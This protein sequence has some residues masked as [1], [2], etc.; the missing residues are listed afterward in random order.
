MKPLS[1]T[2]SLFCN[3][4]KGG[5]EQFWRKSYKCATLAFERHFVATAA[6]VY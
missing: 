4:K 5:Q 2:V 6:T 1:C 3:I